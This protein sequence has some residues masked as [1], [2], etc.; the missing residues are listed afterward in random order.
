MPARVNGMSNAAVV[1]VILVSACAMGGSQQ[2]QQQVDASHADGP[3]VHD[4]SNV[5]GDAKVFHDAPVSHLDAFVPQDA[6]PLTGEGGFCADN[7]TCAATL[8]C[9]VFVCTPGT[10]I[11][12]NICLPN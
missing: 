5:T 7:T 3:T 2:Q 6:P 11:G 8:C 10:P 4:A 1:I 12:A 9:L